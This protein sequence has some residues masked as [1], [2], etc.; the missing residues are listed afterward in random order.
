MLLFYSENKTLVQIGL[1]RIRIS[2]AVGNGKVSFLAKWTSYS[3]LDRA[4]NK[5]LIR[6][7]FLCD[8]REIRL[9]TCI[10]FDFNKQICVGSNIFFYSLLSRNSGK[11][12]RRFVIFQKFYQEVTVPL[13]AYGRALMLGCRKWSWSISWTVRRNMGRKYHIMLGPVLQERLATPDR[14]SSSRPHESRDLQ[15]LRIPMNDS[16]PA[17]LI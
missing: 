17:F 15:D 11:W 13:G 14:A 6:F 3:P 16:Q 9:G 1:A 12:V 2:F 10:W 5:S 4:E 8:V 7:I